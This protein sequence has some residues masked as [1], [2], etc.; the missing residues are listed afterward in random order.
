M[1]LSRR[2][3]LYLAAGAAPPTVSRPAWA[4]TYPARPVRVIV[5]FAA[6][7]PIDVY[8][9]FIAHKLSDHLGTVFYV[10]NIPGVG[11]NIG[12]GQAA[13]A[14]PDGY[15]ILINANN[16]I[17]N[18]SLYGKVPYQ[19]FK[20]FDAVTLAATF[21][22]A[23][24]IN[25]SV[26]AHSVKEL[27][28]LVKAT[29]RKYSFGSPGVG[30][31]SHL[32]GEQ[33]RITLGLDMVHVPYGGSGPAIASAVAGHTPIVFAA[34]SAT[35]PQAKVRNLRLLAVMSKNRSEAFPDA[36]TIAEAGYPDMDGDGW[37]GIFVPAGTPKEI[38]ALLHG[39]VIKIMALADVKEWFATLGFSAV[40][41]TPEQFDAQLRFELEK[42]R[43]VIRAANIKG[44]C[45]DR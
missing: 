13:R 23:L 4:Q 15:T 10:E 9:R 7:G 17:I 40:V 6:G 25:P 35:A 38:I 29:P 16:H 43:R 32:L 34:L 31:P 44:E 42:W 1:T 28:A 8:A 39:E 30:T 19:P 45:G 12:A 18:T 22:T 11:G 27:V 21:A 3:F 41:N 14:K 2:L 37:I 33:F 26:P 20:D 5:P 36:P 24:S